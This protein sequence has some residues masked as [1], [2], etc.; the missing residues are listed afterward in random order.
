MILA[1]H[2]IVSSSGGSAPLLLDTYSG[3]T[4]AYSLRKLRTAY[5]GNAIRIRRSSDN[6]SQDIGFVNGE[7]DTTSI[8]NFVGANSGF[9]SVW[10]D[11]SGNGYNFEQSTLNNQPQLVSGGNLITKNEK[12]TIL[13]DGISEFMTIPTS[14]FSMAFLHT[15]GKSF[16]S[17]VGYNRVVNDGFIINNNY[18]ASA[19]IGY[20]LNTNTA[21]NI[22]S[23]T[24]R[25]VSGQATVSNSTNTTPLTN[26]NLFI[27]NDEKDNGNATA[28][29][30]SK[31]Y[32]NN[33]SSLNLNTL[34]N[35]PSVNNA[36]HDLTIGASSGGSPKY[37]YYD[38]GISQLI[39]WN[40]D[41]SSN[42]VGITTDINTQYLIY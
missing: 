34:T 42:R 1:N 9:V 36:S 16:V 23:F 29:L 19:N 24:T 15:I 40:S 11:Q 33:G 35:S 20:A 4:G 12:P 38:G 3:A 7:L 32:V 26:N 14:T 13:F 31:I 27:I 2:G 17:V 25:G 8:S 30:R 6:T 39:M 18:G 28:S 41:Q 21:R 37:Y 22:D 10:Y 5:T